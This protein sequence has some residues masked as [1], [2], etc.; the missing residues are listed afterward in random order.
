MDNEDLYARAAFGKQVELFWASSV[1]EY[2]RGRARECYTTAVRQL[3]SCDPTDAKLV[4]RCQGDIWKT[5]SLEDWMSAAI[6]DGLKALDLI[7]HP[8]E[9]DNG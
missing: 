9:E 3:K 1:G 6:L 7:E 4:M 2:L 5:E 8:E